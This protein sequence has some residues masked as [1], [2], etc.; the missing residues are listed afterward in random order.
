[1]PEENR[2]GSYV[3]AALEARRIRLLNIS[4]IDD[5][6]VY[7]LSAANLDQHPPFVALSCTWDGQPRDQ[8][9]ICDGSTLEVSKN[10]S[11]VLPYLFQYFGPVNL[12]I[13]A[14]CINQDDESE[15][16]IQVPMMH[17]IYANTSRAIIWLGESDQRSM[18]Q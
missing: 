9:L 6:L 18:K 16:N 8:D 15:K 13:D 2:N 4:S 3:Y 11:T 14:V 7:S 17:E 12:W 5:R 10:V 1:M